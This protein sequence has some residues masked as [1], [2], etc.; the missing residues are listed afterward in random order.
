MKK[1]VQAV[2]Q[3]YE[4][5]REVWR[6]CRDAVE[7]EDAIKSGGERYLPRPSGHSKDEYLAYVNRA[8]WY[9]A[10]ERTL[11]G[12]HGLVF[13]KPPVVDGPGAIETYL[14][15]IDV[16]GNSFQTFAQ[17]VV[18]ELFIVGRV[19]VLVDFPRVEAGEVNSRAEYEAR[20][21]RPYAV[22]YRAENITNWRT[23]TVN[24]KRQLS[25][26]VLYSPYEVE[27]GDGF[28]MNAVQ[29][30]RVL[31]LQDQVYVMEQWDEVDGDF[32]LVS[33]LTPTVDGVPWD[34]IPFQFINSDHLLSDVCKPPL[35]NVVNL[36]VS[37]YRTVADLE[38]GAHWTGV[39][40]PVVIGLSPD[41]NEV[42]LGAEAAMILPVG[43]DAKFLEF[44]GS[45]LAALEKR[46]EV[47]E[48]EMARS[49]LR[50]LATEKKAAEAADTETIRRE[51][52]NSILASMAI[53]VA[54]GLT[55]V[56]EYI[57]TWI[58]AT[59][60]VLVELNTEYSPT[61]IDAPTLTAYLQGWQSGAYTHED[62]FALLQKAGVIAEDRRFDDL[63]EEVENENPISGALTSDD[64]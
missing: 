34:R 32:Q 18:K 44:T 38:N 12:L 21:L 43:G 58:G 29:S 17:M 46:I 48:G 51:G 1:G 20:G 49:A 61:R 10:T 41:Q 50:I 57:S 14:D 3:D 2:H 33:A 19:G 16:L 55:R 5:M 23:T 45:G 64:E 28:T 47:K 36:N 6:R 56:L 42:V 7:G 13:R 63:K 62:L 35:I 53:R 60:G 39:P 22:M 31:R 9:N 26:V 30:Y 4:R 15:A 11:D 40:T 8:Y 25:L 37:H 27:S 59:E 24:G 54:R 52:E